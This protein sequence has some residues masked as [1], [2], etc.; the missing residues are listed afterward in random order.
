M[1]TGRINQV[2]LLSTQPLSPRP[3]RQSCSAAF[4]QRGLP[5]TAEAEENNTTERE[6][7]DE[8]QKTKSAFMGKD[9]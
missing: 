1:T 6:V 5:S 8:S 2:T 9:S 7:I 3:E 4:T